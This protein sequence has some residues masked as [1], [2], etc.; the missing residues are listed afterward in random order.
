M[1]ITN[2][3]HSNGSHEDT[4]PLAR[5][6]WERIHQVGVTKIFGVP[7]TPFIYN[8][9]GLEWVGNTNELN[10]AYSADGYARVN[11]AGCLITTH[12]VGELSAL[13]AIAGSM[14]EQVKVIHVVGQTS[15]K[16]QRG[17]MMIHH[18]IGQSPNHQMFNNASR[19]FRVAAAELQTAKGAAEEID[20]VLRECF[21]KSGPVY[22]F[23]PI[24]LV[25][26]HVPSKALQTPLNVEPE[27]DPKVIDDAAKTILQALESS[28]N[29]ALFVDCL[30]QRRQAVEE[31]KQLVNKLQIPTYDS[32]MAKGIIDA[33]NEHYAALYNGIPSAPGVHEAFQK[34]DF[35]LVLGNLPCDT[36]TGGFTRKIPTNAAYIN[37]EDVQ[38][39]AWKLP[40]VP[41]KAVTKRLIDL[42]DPSKIPHVKNPKH[43]LPPALPEE[44]ADSKLITQSWIWHRLADW[45][46]PHDVV[47]GE[48]GT[49]A[50][51]LPD[52][53]FP[54]DTHWITQTYYGSI[55][56]ATPAALGADLALADRAEKQGTPR[57][58][59]LLITGDGSLM[60]TCQE[61]G[62]MVKQKLA[63]VIFLINNAGY[64]IE[65]VIH[66]AE[67][68]Y[69]DIVP[70]NYEHMLPFFNMPPAQ[71]KKCFHKAHTKA[72]LDAI[73]AL[74]RVQNPTSVQVVEI[75]MDRLDVPWR[76]ASGVAMRGPEAVREMR[77]AGFRVRDLTNSSDFWN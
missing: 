34:H 12:G 54:A 22:I 32:N 40:N 59:T 16:M 48:T 38:I 5:Y 61:I 63:P 27:V 58:R 24:D 14:T 39:N 33:T 8:V 9:D 17:R 36:N 65:R 28:H 50:F 23:L 11:G 21:I 29:P 44:D 19:E 62:N 43:T 15:L 53:T 35:V 2:G 1:A 70:F 64:T 77:E 41:L 7:G 75:V 37:T 42:A 55:G 18:S 49:A 74:D 52:A 72:E 73:L 76:L 56:Y 57:G 69:N 6:L 30:V 60:L 67:C 13:N 46:R 51:G 4:V 3:T 25:D 71:A 66:G 45:F 26:V 68:S 31:A 47:F 20:R 10:A